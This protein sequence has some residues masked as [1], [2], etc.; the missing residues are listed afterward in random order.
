MSYKRRRKQRKSSAVEDKIAAGNTNKS[1]SYV[2]EELVFETLLETPALFRPFEGVS[3]MHTNLYLLF[4]RLPIVSA[5]VSL[6]VRSDEVKTVV[7]TS[8]K[9][10]SGKSTIVVNLAV[11]ATGTR[12]EERR[13]GKE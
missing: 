3:D 7:V 10:G 8:L 9:G 12:S 6:S 13:V 11:E 1:N 2:S 5:Y 4:V